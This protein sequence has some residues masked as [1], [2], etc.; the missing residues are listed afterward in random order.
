MVI[1]QAVG[2]RV[3]FRWRSA[4]FLRI[5]K[6]CA[7]WIL[8]RT[9]IWFSISFESHWFISCKRRPVSYHPLGWSINSE[10][11]SPLNLRLDSSPLERRP[12]IVVRCVILLYGVASR[13][14]TKGFWTLIG[15]PWVDEFSSVMY[16]TNSF[17]HDSWILPLA[18]FERR[19]V[20]HR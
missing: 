8:E 1:R 3:C 15:T 13:V 10:Y 19:S 4:P 12:V 11:A 5:N 20:T 2:Q 6:L 18:C 14:Y 9:L 16:F 7:G 17:P